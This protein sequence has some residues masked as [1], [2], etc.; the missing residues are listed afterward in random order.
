MSEVID[1]LFLVEWKQSK[2]EREEDSM[3][4]EIW[5]TVTREYY[6]SQVK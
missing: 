6:I 3:K 4:I 5:V 1:L 2:S